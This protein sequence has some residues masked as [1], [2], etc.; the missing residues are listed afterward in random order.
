MLKDVH[1]MVT[2]YLADAKVVL[3]HD[4]YAAQGH[5]SS[6]GETANETQIEPPEPLL[7]P[8]QGPAS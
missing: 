5:P 3:V 8:L 1:I 4:E 6:W 2:Y 7:I